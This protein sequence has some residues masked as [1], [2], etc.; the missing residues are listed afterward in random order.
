[1]AFLAVIFRSEMGLSGLRRAGWFSLG[2]MLGL[3]P[4]II[5]FLMYP[6]QF[7]FGNFGYNAELYPML[8]RIGWL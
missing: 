2:L 1:L 5:L 6:N 7:V 8:C 3:L 4:A